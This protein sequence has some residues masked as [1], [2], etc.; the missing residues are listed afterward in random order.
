MKHLMKIWTL[1]VAL[2][3]LAGPAMALDIGENITISDKNYNAVS[4]H[5]NY[6]DQET[7]P[8][9][10][11]G[12]AWDLEG[13]FLDEYNILSLV[14]GYDFSSGYGGYYSGDI[15]L[16]IDDLPQY[17]D[18]YRVTN[19][20]QNYEIAKN[21]GYEFVLDLS[22]NG[23]SGHTYR[24]YSLEDNTVLQTAYYQQNEG[25]SPWR[26]VSGGTELTQYA[27]TFSF[28][29][30]LTDSNTGFSGGT[31]YL[32]TGFDLSFLG[33]DM[34]F[35][36]HF[37]M[38]CGNDNLMGKGTVVPEPSTMLLLGSGLVGLAFCRR[39]KK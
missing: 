28:D 20:Q 13:F 16:S 7:E 12:Q 25:S 24:V 15:F 19:D 6:E 17:G 5:G 8:G 1:V 34:E 29:S 22:F 21:Y 3:L 18:I 36:S 33:H 27:G 38:G 31:H 35:V 32:L 39:R 26:Y 4:W 30:G 14:G 9:M 10:Q 37:T 23:T 2:V 11:T